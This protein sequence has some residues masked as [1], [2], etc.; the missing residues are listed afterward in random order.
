MRGIAVVVCSIAGIAGM[1]R[2]AEASTY[3]VGIGEQFRELTAL[4]PLQPGDVVEVV[5]GFTYQPVTFTADGTAAQP[6]VI[7]GLRNAF[8]K[9][10]VISSGD[11]AM[12]LAGDHYIVEGMELTQAAVRCLFVHAHGLVLRDLLIHDCPGH[13]IEG[14]GS[15]GGDLTLEYSEIHH[16]GRGQTQHQIYVSTDEVMHPGARFRMRFDYV[17]DGNGGNNV[18]SRAE[19]NEI[20][21]NW[22]E[23]ALYHELEL[24]GPDP[25]DAGVPENQ[26][27][28]N[29]DVVGNVLAKGGGHSNFWIARIGGDGTG[30]TFGRYRFVHNTILLASDSAG[31][32]RLFDGI[33][34]FEAHNNVIFRTSTAATTPI[35]VRENEAMWRPSRG[36]V[37][38]HNWVVDAIV[39]GVP[40]ATDWTGTIRGADPGWN[41]FGDYRPLEGSPL[42]DAAD[43]A[44]TGV[45]NRA[46]PMPLVEP[47]FEPP[48]GAAGGGTIIAPGTERPRPRVG[49]LDIGAFEL[50]MGPPVDPDAGVGPG[51]GDGGVDP[52]GDGGTDP[53][54]SGG[55]GC[56]STGRAGDGVAPLAMMLMLGLGRARGRRRS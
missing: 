3:R 27:I 14:G 6:I 17:H 9:R 50:G 7:R 10:P 54:G 16:S 35:I 15:G 8:G 56:C 2:A 20:Y 43:P 25:G 34:T 47:S 19:R 40:A 5:G 37:G 30:Q 39:N 12:E 45:P 42:V 22:I 13:G 23:G 44:P 51:D 36:L 53:T 28:E 33:D 18:K 55:G 49:T 38:S 21:F 4:P 31:A 48:V 32:F 1:A 46:F 52:T 24:I 29:S 26:A 41:G 11:N